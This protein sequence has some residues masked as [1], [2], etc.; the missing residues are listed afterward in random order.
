MIQQLK[1]IL[2]ITAAEE[3]K[4]QI[5]QLKKAIQEKAFL[6]DVRMPWEYSGGTLPGAVNIPLG[7]IPQEL[8]R[9]AGKHQ[10]VVFCRSGNRSKQAQQILQQNGFS[11][12]LDGGGLL[13]MKKIIDSL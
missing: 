9:F 7:E 8:K 3:D 1:K 4:E 13:S 5:H 10:I 12:V 2:G 6:V 11:S